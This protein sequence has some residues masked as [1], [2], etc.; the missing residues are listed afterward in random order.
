MLNYNQIK[1]CIYYFLETRRP[2]G[3]ERTVWKSAAS[4]QTEVEDDKFRCL[5]PSR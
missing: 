2:V 4:S 3:Q 1:L 5:L